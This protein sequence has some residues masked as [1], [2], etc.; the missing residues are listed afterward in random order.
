[1]TSSATAQ[2]RWPGACRSA[3]TEQVERVGRQLQRRTGSLVVCS[4]YVLVSE[5]FGRM[6][7]R[8]DDGLGHVHCHRFDKWKER[9]KRQDLTLF[10]QKLSRQITEQCFHKAEIIYLLLY[11]ISSYSTSKYTKSTVTR[12]HEPTASMRAQ[13][14]WQRAVMNDQR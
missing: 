4:L 7:T 8:G 5:F 1:M 10:L 3:Q 14:I 6:R 13:N 12:F 11:Y 2:G 9:K